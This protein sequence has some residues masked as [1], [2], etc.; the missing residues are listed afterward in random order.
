MTVESLGVRITRWVAGIFGVFLVLATAGEISLFALV[1]AAPFFLVARTP[2][3]FGPAVGALVLLITTFLAFFDPRDGVG[4]F[5]ERIVIT[6]PFFAL[7]LLFAFP[8]AS[9]TLARIALFLALKQGESPAAWLGRMGGRLSKFF[10]SWPMRIFYAFLVT[11]IAPVLYIF[12]LISVI[13]IPLALLL[14][15]VP[16]AAALYVSAGLLHDCVFRRSMGSS[17]AIAASLAIPIAAAVIVAQSANAMLDRRME[18]LIAGDRDQVSEGP[19][20]KLAFVSD[21]APAYDAVSPCEEMC[22]RV[23]LSGGADEVLIAHLKAP[24]ETLDT[25]LPVTAVRLAQTG[26]ACAATRLEG[27]VGAAD[28]AKLRKNAADC[29]AQR[30]ARLGEA[31]AVLVSTQLAKGIRFHASAGLNA[32]ADTVR[33]KRLAFFRAEGGTFRE[34]Y[35][36]TLAWSERHPPIAIPA[37]VHGYGWE[38]AVGFFRITHHANA[39]RYED[40]PDAAAFLSEKLGLDLAV[41]EMPAS[42]RHAAR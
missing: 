4:F 7:G 34:E 28:H 5:P 30:P 17:G 21:S 40:E 14:A 2:R 15:F 9:E 35:R 33:A 24:P 23:L 16:A 25:K 36:R 12:C 8:P 3:K 29:L 39:E 18:A 1:I 20:R 31:D 32:Y 27:D 10:V 6:L 19:I 38:T 41:A 22:I 13:G 42:D 11:L 26:D 37:I